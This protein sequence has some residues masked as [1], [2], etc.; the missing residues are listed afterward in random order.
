MWAVLVAKLLY[1]TAI[2]PYEPNTHQTTKVVAGSAGCNAPPG[3]G[4]D[5]QDPVPDD[6]ASPQMICMMREES[7]SPRRRRTSSDV[8]DG[9]FTH[10]P[11][12]GTEMPGTEMPSAGTRIGGGAAETARVAGTTGAGTPWEFTAGTVGSGTDKPP[13]PFSGDREQWTEWALVTR[14]YFISQGLVT[15][16]ELQIIENCTYAIQYAHM[17]QEQLARSQTM[18]YKLVQMVR[19]HALRVVH[20]AAVGNGFEAWRLLVH[21]MQDLDT[22]QSVGLMNEIMSFELPKY[23]NVEQGL[24]HLDRLVESYRRQHGEASIPDDLLCA[25][26]IRGTEEPLRGHLQLQTFSNY[27]QLKAA[28][29]RYHR[30]QGHWTHPQATSNRGADVDQ[31]AALSKGKG[32][33]RKGKKG[34]DNEIM[35]FNCRG[36]GHSASECPSVRKDRSQW[37]MSSPSSSSASKPRSRSSS[38]VNGVFL[39][40]R[41]QT[42]RDPSET[43][44]HCPG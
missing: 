40:P 11:S 41:L 17:S 34:Q 36:W 15:P 25:V 6:P 37:M 3:S 21:D 28:M 33:G 13:E 10:V 39:S 14:A 4:M 26:V 2:H 32:K 23:T 16:K 18:F 24:S 1:A 12:R 20:T 35:C 43:S 29:L 27:R 44:E 38:N 42:K 30:A 31:L 5:G 19:G 22:N 8:S 7:Q 9:S